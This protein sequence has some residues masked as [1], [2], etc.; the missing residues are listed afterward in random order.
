MEVLYIL[1]MN[2][3]WKARSE[4]RDFGDEPIVYG[5]NDIWGSELDLNGLPLIPYPLYICRRD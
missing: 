2:P 5:I 1:L 3:P 4:A